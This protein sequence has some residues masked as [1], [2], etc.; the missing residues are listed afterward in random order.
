MPAGLQLASQL[1]EP[2]FTPSTKAAQGHDVNIDFAGAVDRVGA[3]AALAAKQ[4]SLELYRRAAAR[5]AEAGL[6]L[7][8]TKFELGY[9]DGVLSLCD[10]V[11]T[12]DSSRLWPADQVVPGETPPAP[13]ASGPLR[14]SLATAAPGSRRPP[15]PPLPVVVTSGGSRRYVR[16]AYE[17]RHR[18]LAGR[19]VRC[20]RHEVRGASR[21]QLRPRIADPEGAT[22]E[23]IPPRSAST[24]WPTSGPS[25]SFSS[26]GRRRRRGSSAP[27]RPG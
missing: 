23:R 18:S 9:V 3:E 16:R 15:P 11:C 26:R 22:I 5:C 8:D 12:P 7:A 2:I 20:D 4:V 24:A 14:D 27:P 13:S 6:I 21:V 19:L 25:R 1:D 10:E 17:A